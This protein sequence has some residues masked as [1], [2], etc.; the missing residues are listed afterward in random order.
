MKL[1]DSLFGKKEDSLNERAEKLV[2]AAKIQAVASFVPML[3]KFPFLSKVKPTDWDFFITVAGVFIASS[4]LEQLRLDNKRKESLMD[5]VSNNLLEWNSDGIAAFD[6]C[7]YLFEKVHEELSVTAE[8]QKDNKFLAADS[9]GM[10]VTWN[11]L[12][13]KPE[14][15]DEINFSRTIGLITIHAFSNW[16]S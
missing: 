15:N 12:Q 3:D 13:H 9:L 16:W 5:I 10:W 8:Y 7:K 1:F 14:N 11:L 6:D 2:T 4:I